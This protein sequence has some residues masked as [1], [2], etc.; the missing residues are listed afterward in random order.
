MTPP[1]S[2]LRAWGPIAF[3]PVV[4]IVAHVLSQLS[5]YGVPYWAGFRPLLIAVPTMLL[6][7]IV[8]SILLG[9]QRGSFVAAIVGTFLAG[10]IFSTLALL[11]IAAL[12][13]VLKMRRPK[14]VPDWA[15][16]T[17]GLNVVGAALLA[18]TL[19]MAWST[20]TF[21]VA[22]PD[23]QSGTP[24]PGDPNIYMLMLDAYPRSDTLADWGYDN[25]PFI[26]ELEELGFDVSRQSHSNYT[27][28]WL[29]LASMADFRIITA[30]EFGQPLP[31][32]S[33]QHRRFSRLFNEGRAW[34]LLRQ[35]GYEL[36]APESAFVDLALYT[37]DQTIGRWGVNAFE[38]DLLRVSPLSR[39][40]L[41]SDGV[42]EANRVRV[43]GQLDA[44]A[45]V[46]GGGPTFTWSHIV[47]PHA[48]AVFGPDGEPLHHPCYPVNCFFYQ[49]DAA[50]MGLQPD[51]L[52]QMLIGQVQYLN[53]LIGQTVSE[54]VS[55]D[56]DAVIVI[57]SDHGA[58]HDD[59]NDEYFHTFFAARTPEQPGLFPSDVAM[60]TTLAVL[61]NAYFDADIPVPNGE[62]QFMTTG[63]L[64][65]L[66]AWTDR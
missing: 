29:S 17:R 30:D 47:N 20:E 36:V 16:M 34:S 58:R 7:Q 35:R 57:L 9:R 27:K 5:N 1:Q 66:Q 3:Y 6:L 40:G 39:I 41:V 31:P 25:E 59:P 10:A 28:T 52:E 63:T 24:V 13:T 15:A 54:I 22:D 32:D 56:P 64:L 50:G 37:A 62:A 42:M 26:A 14:A 55:R 60:V 49:P 19:V 8:L 46:T 4:A 11:S 53:G 48:P 43:T 38:A 2:A 44:T 18:V 51:E 45:N 65:D 12:R 23:L 61:L 33:V 21:I